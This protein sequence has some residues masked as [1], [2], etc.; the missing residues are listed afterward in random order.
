MSRNLARKFVFGPGVVVLAAVSLVTASC[1]S[2]GP[3]LYPVHGKV[4]FKGEPAVGARVIFHPRNDA[5]LRAPHPAGVAGAD[6]TFTLTSFQPDDGAPA[7]DY[8]V[9]VVWPHE[10]SPAPKARAPHNQ[11]VKNRLGGSFNNPARPVLLLAH[12][13]EGNNELP[14][15][16]L[17]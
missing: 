17:R 1:R 14:A 12:V 11:A 6:G 2:Q 4:L 13:G 16:E 9:A 3:R 5:D 8:T 15:F 10:S 7:G